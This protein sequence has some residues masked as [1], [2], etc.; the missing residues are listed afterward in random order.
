MS[1]TFTI[2]KN[3][4][5][6]L[7]V[8]IKNAEN[9]LK[10]RC[11]C[12]ECNEKLQAIQGKSENSRTWH[13]R[14]DNTNSKCPGNNE[15]ALHQY[16]KRI[17]FESNVINTFK[18]KVYYTDPRL[19]T[20]IDKYRSD[21]CVK[22]S[23]MELHFEV[24]VNNDVKADKKMYYHSNKINCIKI[25]LTNPELLTADPDQIKHAILED[26]SNKI[27][28][29]WNDAKLYEIPFSYFNYFKEII[30]GLILVGS[31]I[32]FINSL[33]GRSLNSKKFR[34]R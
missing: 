12:Y 5:T 30:G 1:A 28:I 32:V 25:D 17:L 14:H 34:R 11:I 10:C 13:Y 20:V 23:G 24:V 33:L 22:Y 6:N 4:D 29:Q 26:K 16:A 8:H 31:I 9:G 18:K 19:E 21:V 2:G 27:F 3:I 7:P 15:T